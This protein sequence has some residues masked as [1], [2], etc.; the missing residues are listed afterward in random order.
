M[1]HGA[2]LVRWVAESASDGTKNSGRRRAAAARFRAQQTRY[3]EVAVPRTV[4]SAGAGYDRRFFI[5]VSRS[6][7][8]QR[9]GRSIESVSVHGWKFC[10]LPPCTKKTLPV[11]GQASVAR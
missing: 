3:A 5:S 2:N 8:V 7:T 10:T 11:A 9:S 4:R 1:R 6:A